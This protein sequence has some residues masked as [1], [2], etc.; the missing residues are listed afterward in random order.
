MKGLTSLIFVAAT[1]VSATSFAGW[2]AIA[3][4][5]F[6][7]TRWGVSYNQPNL[8]MAQQAAL[9]ACQATGQ[10]C[11]IYNW[12]FNS[13]IYGPYGTWTCN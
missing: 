3:L 12:E 6:D 13:C 5:R 11:Y 4:G 2:G 10:P 8:F 9:M 1:L 7:Q